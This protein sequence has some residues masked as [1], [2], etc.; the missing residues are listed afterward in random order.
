M[1]PAESGWSDKAQFVIRYKPAGANSPSLEDAVDQP[2]TQADRD[3]GVVSDRVGYFRSSHSSRHV[4]LPVLLREVLIATTENGKTSTLRLITNLTDVSATTIG[5]L[6][7]QRWQVELFFRW[8]KSIA[9][10]QHLISHNR[11]GMLTQLYV[12]LI[13]VLLMYLHTGYRP[14]KYLFA[15]LSAGVSLEELMP[16]LRERERQCELARQSAARR[17]SAKKS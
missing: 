10:F 12:T 15:L 17:R 8:L 4:I 9:N 5:L 11:E 16:I 13:A 2:L 14:S 7:R 1:P 6:Y 3:A